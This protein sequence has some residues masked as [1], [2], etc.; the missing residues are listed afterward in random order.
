M[1][2]LMGLCFAGPISAD[3]TTRE[4]ARRGE[5][6]ADGWGLAWYPDRSA[7]IVKEPVCWQDSPYTS[8]LETYQ[9]LLSPLYI[10]H[11]RHKTVG[12]PPTHADTHPFKRELGGREYCFAHNGTLTGFHD[13]LPL[14][15]FHPVGSTD[16]EHLFCHLLD[17]IARRGDEPAGEEGWRWLHGRLAA[18]NRMGKLNC[19]M[20]D[21]RLLFCYHDAAGYKGLALRKIRVH[22]HETR[23]LEDDD[24]RI[25]LEGES[26]NHG[27][28]VATHPLTSTGWHAFRAGELIVLEGGVLRFS[29]HRSLPAPEFGPPAP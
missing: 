12:G 22:G 6:N 7:V 9:H 1:C 3:F 19:L 20:S 13:E 29:S 24:M 2:E 16:S 21:G 5:E 17:A 10:A 8:F 15:R 4:F 25:D 18:L 26:S 23:R 14:S 28:V 11:V 27:F